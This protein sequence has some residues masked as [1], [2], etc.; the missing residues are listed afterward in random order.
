MIENNL[1]LKL[2]DLTLNFAISSYSHMLGLVFRF[3]C[4]K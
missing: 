3:T 4:P 1:R 2:K